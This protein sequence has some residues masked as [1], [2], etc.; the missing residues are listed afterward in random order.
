MCIRDSFITGFQHTDVL[1]KPMAEPVTLFIEKRFASLRGL[2]TNFRITMEGTVKNI[3]G[4]KVTA[5]GGSKVPFQ[6]HDSHGGSLTCCALED[7]VGFGD[8]A[9]NQNVRLF[10]VYSKFH[11]ESGNSTVFLFADSA[12][13]KVPEP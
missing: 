11:A 5:S 3:T 12:V 4:G 9:E 1:P 7:C 8:I 13:Q 2:K 10:N 6:L